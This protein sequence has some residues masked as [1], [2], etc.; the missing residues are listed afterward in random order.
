VA[1]GGIGVAVGLALG[2]T[3]V[4]IPLAV[5]V[6]RH[7][8]GVDGDRGAKVGHL[9]VQ[10][11]GHPVKAGVQQR[12]ERPQL[13]GEA[14]AGMHAR[15][16]G[17]VGAAQGGAE[18]GVLADQGDGTGPSRQGVEALGQRH[19]DHGADR[20]AGPTRPAGRRKL[21]H[22]LG[23]LGAVKQRRKLYRV[24]A[25]WY[26]R[27]DH[28]AT[29]SWSRPPE[30]PTSWGSL[31]ESSTRRIIGRGCD[32]HRPKYRVE[33]VGQK[34][35]HLLSG[36]WPTRVAGLPER[37]IVVGETGAGRGG[38]TSPPDC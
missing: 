36:G 37:A 17:N 25:R 16:A 19:A 11:G 4:E 21:V 6:G 29:F 14:V 12:L 3:L 35:S 24:R 7:V 15:H 10:G 38:A 27:S 34:S 2:A 8:A 1:P 28:G 23:D 32:S 5:G 30:A 22:K 33:K 9:L 18:G 13:D 31:I 26:L 20:V